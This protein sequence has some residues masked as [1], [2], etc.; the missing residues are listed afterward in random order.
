M[1]TTS[2]DLVSNPQKETSSRSTSS[3]S[4]YTRV[5]RGSGASS[6]VYT[7]TALPTASDYLRLLEMDPA[8]SLEEPLRCRLLTAHRDDVSGQYSALSY[9]W[10]G[11][12]RTESIFVEGCELHVTKNLLQALRR[13]RDGKRRRLWADAICI[14]QDDT[15][16]RTQQVAQMTRTYH[17]AHGVIVWLG[18]D[19]EQKDGEIAI[20]FFKHVYGEYVSREFLNSNFDPSADR[21]RRLDWGAWRHLSVI[22]PM[23]PNIPLPE[24][25]VYH[26]AK[27]SFDGEVLP[28]IAA[29]SKAPV[30]TLSQALELFWDRPWFSRKWVIQE[31]YL[32]RRASM[33]CGPN[34]IKL[35]PVMAFISII[36]ASVRE[37]YANYSHGPLRLVAEERSWSPGA[38]PELDRGDTL[39]TMQQLG[40]YAC[41]DPRDHIAAFLGLWPS[42]GFKVDY[43]RETDTVYVDFATHMAERGACISLLDVR[44]DTYH[45]K[46]API[47]ERPTHATIPSWVPDWRYCTGSTGLDGF[48]R[49]TNPDHPGRPLRLQTGRV[50]QSNELM[51]KGYKLT[52]MHAAESA[53][54]FNGR[55]K[56]MHLEAFYPTF[57]TASVM[58]GDAVLVLVADDGGSGGI[59]LCQHIP[60]TTNHYRLFWRMFVHLDHEL[61]TFDAQP[62][63]MVLV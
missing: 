56:A 61:P 30:A 44:L 55:L 25:A 51:L 47:V 3:T 31:I 41:Q 28:N 35:F 22:D 50:T 13:L 21:L 54:V 33:I 11:N 18:E 57:F 24:P 38:R 60:E 15:E 19:S 9:T 5:A 48:L 8:E 32:S 10:S 34:K 40:L 42:L 1:Q 63:M 39:E 4:H 59:Y 20:E 26:D 2:H 53:E 49:I 16:E 17:E 29:C 12:F 23:C 36:Y 7:Y 58:A 6:A 37:L 62:E 45:T 46:T 14:N 43:S 27:A 52:Q